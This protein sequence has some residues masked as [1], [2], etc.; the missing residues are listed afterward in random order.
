MSVCGG[1]AADKAHA[2]YD[3]SRSQGPLTIDVHK[4]FTA[5]RHTLSETRFIIVHIGAG[6]RAIALAK[7]AALFVTEKPDEAARRRKTAWASSSTKSVS[8]G[9]RRD[10][11]CMS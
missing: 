5:S 4:L 6:R 1:R 9:L 11:P 10:T 8:S 7:H 2:A 3:R